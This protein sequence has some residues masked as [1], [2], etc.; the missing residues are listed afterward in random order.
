MTSSIDMR[1][2]ELALT[3]LTTALRYARFLPKKQTFLTKRPD[4]RFVYLARSDLGL[5]F[6]RFIQ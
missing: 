2:L 4:N 3:D 1:I 6:R 5:L